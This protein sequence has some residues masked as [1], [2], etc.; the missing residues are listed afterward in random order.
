MV[1]IPVAECERVIYDAMS[2]KLQLQWKPKKNDRNVEHPLR[3]IG[4]KWIQP[5]IKATG[6]T[7]GKAK[8]VGLTKAI[9][10]HSTLC[11]T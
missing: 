5:R 9:R 3:K 10:V 2:M 8:S 7:K 6:T 1:S 11:R 4:N